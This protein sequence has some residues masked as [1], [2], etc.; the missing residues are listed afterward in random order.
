[1]GLFLSQT[2][3][4]TKILQKAGLLDC[5]PLS[6]PKASKV[7]VPAHSPPFSDPTLYRALV[8]SLQYL[9]FTRS[10]IAF[11]VNYVCQHLQQPTEFHFTLV[12]HILRYI[13]GT[14]DFGH[15]LTADSDLILKA[16]SDSNW[17][18]CP[19][20]QRSTTGYHTFVG[21]NC[22]SWSAKKQPAISLSRVRRRNIML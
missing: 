7:Q 17:V 16:F 20:T 3:Y 12:K 18:G 14:L 15:L 9:T 22:V 19:L 4:A 13:K 10:D 21:S 1:M 5:K 11:S 6:I 2:R 8:G